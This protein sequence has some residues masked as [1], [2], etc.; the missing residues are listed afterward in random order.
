MLTKSL[1]RSP[2]AT[3]SFIWLCGFIFYIVYLINCFKNS[4]TYERLKRFYTYEE[5]EKF[6]K[7]SLRKTPI[8]TIAL[9]HYYYSGEVGTRI[10]YNAGPKIYTDNLET[11]FHCSSWVNEDYGIED[12]E[13]A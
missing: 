2:E 3:I 8:I 4:P 1:S 7:S 9:R 10:P 13:D 5:T 11:I 12:I 6:V